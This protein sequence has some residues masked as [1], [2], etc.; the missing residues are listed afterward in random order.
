M[1]EGRDRGTSFVVHLPL[2]QRAADERTRRRNFPLHTRIR[3]A[4]FTAARHAGRRLKG[5]P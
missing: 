3:D 1:S 5:D 2:A 4:A